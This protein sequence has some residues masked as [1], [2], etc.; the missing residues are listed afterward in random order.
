VLEIPSAGKFPLPE[1]PA[2]KFLVKT[3]VHM[4]SAIRRIIQKYVLQAVVAREFHLLKVATRSAQH[5]DFHP[6]ARFM[7]VSRLFGACSEIEW[8]LMS[9]PVILRHYIRYIRQC[10]TKQAERPSP[11]CDDLK[12]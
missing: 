12:P 7:G 3:R 10:L 9:D 5:F 8:Q 4:S 6:R 1:I 2:Q 11:S